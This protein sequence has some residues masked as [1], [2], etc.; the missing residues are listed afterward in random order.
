MFLTLG[1]RET[2]ADMAKRVVD[3]GL[4]T[5]INECQTIAELTSLKSQYVVGEF[6]KS[7]VFEKKL[8]LIGRLLEEE[9]QDEQLE[10]STGP[11][12][13]EQRQQFLIEWRELVN[14]WRN[15]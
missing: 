4:A 7:L 2:I 10:F 13:L 9:T 15:T 1:V 14:S 11:W 5:K 3:E 8:K 12:G 6:E